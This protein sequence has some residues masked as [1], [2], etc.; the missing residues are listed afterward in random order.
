MQCHGVSIKYVGW[1]L[2]GN[3]NAGTSDIKVYYAARFLNSC[4]TGLSEIKLTLC[5]RFLK[6]IVIY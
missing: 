6:V 2:N 4:D 5:F 1:S 3:C